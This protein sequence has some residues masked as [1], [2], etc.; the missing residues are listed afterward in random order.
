MGRYRRA[1][2]AIAGAV[3]AAAPVGAAP[4][5]ISLS[6]SEG[7]DHVASARRGYPGVIVRE[8]AR[9]DLSG[10]L[11]VSRRVALRLTLRNS[12]ERLALGLRAGV[13]VRPTGLGTHL[14]PYLAADAGVLSPSY[15]DIPTVE[16]RVAAGLWL[17]A[18]RRVALYAETSATLF[19]ADRGLRLGD[20]LTLGVA[21]V[22]S[23]F[24]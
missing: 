2:I 14:R 1:L 4:I 10:L 13:L 5:A 21:L 3:A 20:A 16:L 15:L 7:V 24:W 23:S 12:V 9:V 11:A 22:G 17:R 18:A 6:L 19:I 8:D